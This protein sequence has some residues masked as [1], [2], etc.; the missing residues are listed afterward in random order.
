MH[1]AQN[2]NVKWINLLQTEESKSEIHGR[3]WCWWC[4]PSIGEG[5][6]QLHSGHQGEMWSSRWPAH[7]WHLASFTIV[8]LEATFQEW[9]WIMSLIEFL[10]LLYFWWLVQPRDVLSGPADQGRRAAGFEKS[11]KTDSCIP[12]SL[13]SWS[14]MGL[15]MRSEIPA[16]CEGF[17]WDSGPCQGLLD[18]KKTS[19]VERLRE[20]LS[21]TKCLEGK[22]LKSVKAELD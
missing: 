9:S 18:T 2:I 13:V 8:F 1:D 20:I 15:I 17:C 5:S 10:L 4:N 21:A 3:A 14:H 19:H 22:D 7:G 16:I 12:K 11:S 6:I